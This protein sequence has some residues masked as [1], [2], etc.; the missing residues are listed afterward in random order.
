M[1]LSN[2]ESFTSPFI[3][4][5]SL[6]LAYNE[7]PPGNINVSLYP[8]CNG[9]CGS[10]IPKCHLPILVNVNIYVYVCIFMFI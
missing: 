4:F 2:V 8:R 9:V 3:T 10:L 1:T 6:I 5:A 7:P